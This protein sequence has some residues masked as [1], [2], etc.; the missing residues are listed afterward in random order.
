MVKFL[1]LSG[2]FFTGTSVDLYLCLCICVCDHSLGNAAVVK[3]SEVSSHTAKVMKELLPL[4]L[5]KV[6]HPS[7]NQLPYFSGYKAHQIISRRIN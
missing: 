1:F 2:L 4:Y 5:D 3:P 6:T 7:S